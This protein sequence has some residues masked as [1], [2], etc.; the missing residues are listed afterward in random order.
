MA[1]F[2]S[3]LFGLGYRVIGRQAADS[4]M[5]RVH[6]RYTASLLLLLAIIAML[7]RNVGQTIACMA[8][9]HM[10]P[11]MVA[12]T[13]SECWIKPYY[14]LVFVDELPKRDIERRA[15]KAYYGW[16]PVLLVLQ[17][18]MFF[19]PRIVWS[20][21]SLKPGLT[22]SLIEGAASDYNE[23]VSHD[24]REDV[25][26]ITSRVIGQHLSD[27]CR[28]SSSSGYSFTRILW[29]V[30]GYSLSG[31]YLLVKLL[32]FLNVLGQ[33]ILIS[34]LL[35]WK[36]VNLHAVDDGSLFHR[37]Y[38]LPY[39]VMCDLMTLRLGNLHKFSIQCS[40]P[41]NLFHENVY[42]LIWW[43]FLFLTGATF[44]NLGYW[45]FRI[46]FRPGHVSFMK[47][48]LAALG[49]VPGDVH[50]DRV[51]TSFCSSYLHGDGFLCLKLLQETAGDVMTAKVLAGI[52]ENYKRGV[53]SSEPE[54]L[55]INE[56]GV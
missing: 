32:Y 25:I 35:G 28:R 1:N 55:I 8:P 38:F 20:L 33:L 39:N 16:I 9:A 12:Y 31:L 23:A 6:G 41:I 11:A 27:N 13:N 5:D 22:S 17:A 36:P 15:S 2:L 24:E 48:S 10:T 34:V 52:F 43:W 19:V 30:Y 44:F 3:H 18:A 4:F 26:K 49:H 53:K 56:S 29:M 46:V 47:S 37:S 40:L 42:V 14:H 21:G 7:R 45:I 51:L 50:G 54:Q